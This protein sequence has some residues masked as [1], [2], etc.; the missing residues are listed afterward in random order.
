VESGDDDDADW[1]EPLPEV[2]V[3]MPDYGAELPLWGERWGNIDWHFTKF[4]RLL[5]DRLPPGRMNSTTIF[6]PGNQAG[7][8]PAYGTVGPARQM[9]WQL[10]CVPSWVHDQNWL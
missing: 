5:L 8:P 10:P 3:L 7:D 6:A 1:D 4:S 2:V 9:T